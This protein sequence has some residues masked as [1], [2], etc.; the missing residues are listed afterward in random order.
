MKHLTRVFATLLIA[1]TIALA[2]QP[3]GAASPNIPK[4]M[5]R[6]F[7]VFLVHTPQQAASD[8]GAEQQMM[9]GHLAFMRQMLES[10]KYII[11]GPFLDRG[12]IGGM[13]VAAAQSEDEI[14]GWEAADPLV[15]SGR[16]KVEV[17]PAMLPSLDSVKVEF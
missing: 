8:A 16:A 6:Y 7:V 10:R 13:S 4:N 11:A 3:S 5:K 1:A 2:Q 15:S 14:R 17:H 9:Q 12:D